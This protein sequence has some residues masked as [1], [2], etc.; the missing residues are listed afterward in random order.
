[1]LEHD[2]LHLISLGFHSRAVEYV[3][4]VGIIG[5]K[6]FSNLLGYREGVSYAGVLSHDQETRMFAMTE[7]LIEA[8]QVVQG[9]LMTPFTKYQEGR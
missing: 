6:A 9:S 7:A 5:E 3:Y 8:K 1:M 4:G 2:D